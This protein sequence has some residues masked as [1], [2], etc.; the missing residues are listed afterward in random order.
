MD[1]AIAKAGKVLIV[2]TP[3]YKRK[4]EAKLDGVGFEY[5]AIERSLRERD[6]DKTKVIPLLRKG[7]ADSSIP[8][9][10]RGARTS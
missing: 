5:A 4:A 3:E 9:G 2:L 1:K 8:A 10:L 6:S 7:S